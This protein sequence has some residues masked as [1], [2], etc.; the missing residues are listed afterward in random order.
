[1]AVVLI[2]LFL[3]LH[4]QLDCSILT[5]GMYRCIITVLGKWVSDWNIYTTTQMTTTIQMT[6]GRL[7]IVQFHWMCQAQ[8]NISKWD[9][10]K[11]ES[12]NSFSCGNLLKFQSLSCACLP[13]YRLCLWLY[14][15]R[16][17]LCLWLCVCVLLHQIDAKMSHWQRLATFRFSF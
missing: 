4:S 6:V 10:I 17:C 9:T 14:A 16:V 15:I 11:F 5:F 3:P 13:L 12:L 1:M 8:S 7:T 2:F